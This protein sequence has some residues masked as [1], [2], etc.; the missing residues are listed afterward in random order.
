MTAK[1]ILILS[2][3]YGTERDELIVPLER[4]KELGH[5]VTLATPNGGAVQTLKSDKHP[6]DRVPADTKV[7]DVTD[8]YDVIVLPGGALNAD[9]GRMDADICRLVK[10]QADAG[11]PIAAICHAPWVLVE[12]G[13]ARGK[14]L[15]SYVS[16]RTDTVNAGATWHDEPVVTSDANG[17]TLVTSR[18][19]HDLDAFVRAIDAL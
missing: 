11:R 10:A 15:T 5:Q 12:T 17:W 1:K 19:P 6:T 14:D 3:E 2:T 16:I 9:K 18:N 8:D 13:L 4:L 7:A